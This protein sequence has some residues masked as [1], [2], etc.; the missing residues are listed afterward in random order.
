MA[1][2]SCTESNPPF[3]ERLRR[4][5]KRRAPQLRGKQQGGGDRRGWVDSRTL[6]PVQN[7]LPPMACRSSTESNPPFSE[8]LRRFLKRRAPQLRGKQQGGGDRRV[9]G[10]IPGRC[11]RC[12]I[13]CHRWPADLARSPTHHFPSVL[14]ASYDK[15]R[16]DGPINGGLV[17]VQARKAREQTSRAPAPNA[18]VETHPPWYHT[19]LEILLCE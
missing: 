18:W 17:F 8:R 1:C 2:R 15:R 16:R 3:P 4:F 13:P 6:S 12:K 5:L 10:S 9:G 14:A 7:P 11:R 19:E